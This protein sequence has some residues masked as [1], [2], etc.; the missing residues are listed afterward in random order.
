[1]LRT[2]RIYAEPAPE[3]GKRYLVDRLWP[4]GI[5]KAR[6]SLDAWLKDVAP[7]QE[8]RNWF[9]HDPARWE[10]FQ[11]RYQA[12]LR[13]G[14]AWELVEKLSRESLQGTVTLLY[15][16]KDESLNN[17]VCLKQFIENNQRPAP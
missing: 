12:E 6:A 4:R 8:L 3:D 11:E 16:A 5:S 9:D 2:K 15:A 13:Q 14:A 1:M 7:S 10:A 17:A